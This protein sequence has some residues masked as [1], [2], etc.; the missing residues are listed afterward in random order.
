MGRGGIQW[1]RSESFSGEREVNLNNWQE[2]ISDKYIGNRSNERK[3]NDG[4]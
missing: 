3:S 4:Y 2:S 1:F